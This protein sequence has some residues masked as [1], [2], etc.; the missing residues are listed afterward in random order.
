MPEKWKKKMITWK[1]LHPSYQHILW[2]YDM[3]LAFLQEH[4]PWIVDT[5]L[6]YTHPIQRCD[7]FRLFVVYHYGGIYV[8][9]DEEPRRPFDNLLEYNVLLPQT[10]RS[11]YW[12]SNFLIGSIPKHPFLKQC[13]DSLESRKNK[14]KWLGRHTHVMYSTGPMFVTDMLKKYKGNDI[15]ILSAQSVNGTVVNDDGEK[16]SVL[17]KHSL[18]KTWNG[19]DTK[20]LNFFTEH[21]K[22]LVILLLIFIIVVIYYYRHDRNCSV[23]CDR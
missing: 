3:S 15:F 11:V 21:W 19:W 8:D 13:I 1:E 12:V 17:L 7:V 23:V 14:Y 18:G 6:S 9:L 4:Y 10:T 5:W 20:V 22:E 2:D 16:L